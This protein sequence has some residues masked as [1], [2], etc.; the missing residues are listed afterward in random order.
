MTAPLNGAPAIMAGG[1]STVGASPSSSMLWLILPRMLLLMGVIAGTFYVLRLVR[2][3]S[4]ATLVAEEEASLS[5]EEAASFDARVEARKRELEGGA[6]E[7]GQPRRT[8]GRRV[9]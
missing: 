5:E 3:R 2:Q 4:Q 8:F 1:P 7:P 6:K 9:S